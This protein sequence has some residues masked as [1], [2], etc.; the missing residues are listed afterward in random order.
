M[1]SFLVA[2]GVVSFRLD[3]NTGSGFCL[4]RFR[5]ANGTTLENALDHYLSMIFFGKPLP[6]FP[7]HAL[8]RSTGLVE[9]GRLLQNLDFTADAALGADIGVGG[10]APAIRPEI[11][12]GLDERARIG[13]HVQDALIEALGRDRLGQ[14]FGDA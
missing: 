8:D 4:T 14:E 1:A 7:D 2:A 6:T 13:D 10:V 3:R 11:G 9:Q 5:D 12:L